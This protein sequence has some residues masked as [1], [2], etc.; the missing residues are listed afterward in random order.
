VAT[1][2]A[3][4]TNTGHVILDIGEDVGALVVY[5]REELHGREI[6]VSPKQNAALRTHVEVLERR[7][8]TR[9]M[10][11]AVFP[12]LPAGTYSVWRDFL[13][14]DEVTVIG[15]SVAEVEWRT[16]SE[17]PVLRFSRP[18]GHVATGPV[19]PLEMLPPRYRDGQPVCTISMGSAPMR[20]D[21]RGQVA[22]D[23]M[24]TDF[25]DLALAGGPPHRETLL[26]P[27]TAVEIAGN[28]AACSQVMAEI[29]RGLRL[30]TGLPTVRSE[31]AGWV[32]L[33][34]GSERMA[35]WLV[36]AIAVE[37]VSVRREECVLYLPVGPGYRL[38]GEIK[39]VITV[40]A[41][42]HHYWAEHCSG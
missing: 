20:F 22:W 29:E 7:M 31:I 26:Q 15:G 38:D 14:D 41:K 8:G 11:A 16:L 12:T 40:A 5:T 6:D 33:R 42:T 9:T 24:W 36:R 18:H 28:A 19:A 13:T 17:T 34:C 23:R 4:R 30:V 3:E 32:G 35:R 2:L 27:A 39:N 10:Y 37:N 25:C 1:A 21:E